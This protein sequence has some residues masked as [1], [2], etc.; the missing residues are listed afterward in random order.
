MERNVVLVCVSASFLGVLAAALGF[1]AEG[2]RIKVSDV[3]WATSNTCTYP[4][5]PALALGLTSALALLVAQ[6]IINTAAGC[7]CYKKYSY[8]SASK[9]TIALI[10][11]VISWVT[12]VIAFLLL[13]TGAALNDQ[14]G[15]QQTYF[16]DYCF[17][18]KGGVFSGGAVCSLVCVSLGITYYLALSLAKNR[19]PWGVHNNQG[20]ALA[21]PQCPPQRTQP[22]FV[23]E[24]TYNRR[25][26]P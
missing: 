24:D 8:P 7:F 11:F 15:E 3:Q 20:I 4:K 12:F 2:T 23:N 13:L 10:S 9:W 22:V 16:G 26:F 21:Q 5:S 25:Q 1:A 19:E 18:V 14:R 17:V 6:I